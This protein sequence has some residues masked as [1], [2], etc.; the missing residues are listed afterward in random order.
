V[1]LR[2][3]E[4]ED[5]VVPT[6]LGQQL[7]PA[8]YP[9]NQNIS[10]APVAVNSAA[11]INSIGG[12]IKVHPDWGA[13][14]LSNGNQPL[15]GIPV[16]IVHGNTTAT[17]NVI[18]DNYPG[19]SD[20]TPVPIPANAVI[21]GDY[22][23]GP[24]PNGGGYK[25]GQRGDSHLIVWDVDN[26]VAYELYGATRPSD[27]TLFPNNS[28]V[29][30]P[31]TDGQW[32]AA[33][34]TVWDMKTDNFRTLGDTSADA[35]GL[36]ILAGLA[37]PDEGLPVALGGQGAINH[38]L[39]F[40]LPSGDVNAQYLYPASHVV[41]S[42]NSGT[43]LP[44]GAR[45]RLDN[46]QA[47]NVMISTMGPEAQIIAHTMQQYGLVLADIGSPM[48]VS[49]TSASV[50]ASNTIQFTWNMNDVLGLSALTASDFQV[51]DLTP[52]VTGLSMNSG[53]VGSTITITGQNFS[54][55]AG[56][57]SVF[58]GSK[59]SPSVQFVDDSHLTV[60]VPNGSGTVH[61]EVQSG[62]NEID[63]NN[64]SDN[65]NN[66]IFGYGTSAATPADQFTY[67]AQTFSSTNSNAS[68]ATSTIVSAGTDVLTLVV[69]DTA[70]NPV[71]NLASNAFGFS[72]SGGTSAGTF[73]PVAATAIAGTYTTTFTATTPG[74]ANT[75]SA[76]VSG[77]T[78]AAMPTITVTPIP[79][80]AGSNAGSTSTATAPSAA[81]P[82]G[83]S[84]VAMD[85]LFAAK[86]LTSGN[87]LLAI[88]GLE[89]FLALLS[90]A[91]PTEQQQLQQIFYSDLLANL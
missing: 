63:P 38:A 11:I 24:N 83:S 25:S 19:E 69:K 1:I 32:H 77:V 89:D 48:Y 45:L 84:Q 22:Q 41:G 57:L 73:G 87:F 8:D 26:N 20:I 85:A 33:Q 82:G 79:G 28:N 35:A 7:F 6:I 86:G 65:V 9:W 58:F 91:P 76:T 64:P 59:A 42:L 31:H 4:L 60:V 88:L 46:T 23:N 14:S 15:Y 17:K 30:L 50:D 51:V 52:V 81:A 16:N 44:L 10:N 62:V 12:S 90:S 53:L 61:V 47:V 75:L 80:S 70:G 18:I 71:N 39:R 2:L 27:Q 67:S 55:A 21:E 74:T 13:D 72:L 29:E 3:E 78:L 34:E 68:F 5:R 40:T 66:P 37:R 43:A 36:S 49:G 56:H 54:G